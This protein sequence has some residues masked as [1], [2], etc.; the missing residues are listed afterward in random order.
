MKLV[1]NTGK[2]VRH[3]HSLHLN[4]LGLLCWLLCGAEA[5]WPF[6]GGYVPVSPIL[7]GVLAGLLTAL[8]IPARVVLQRQLSGDRDADQQD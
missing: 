5:A 8:A 6:L 1:P 2:V 7:F 3:S 4:V